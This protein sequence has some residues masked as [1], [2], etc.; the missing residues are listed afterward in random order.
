MRVHVV[1]GQDWPAGVHSPV[2]VIPGFSC[3][4]PGFGEIVPGG[5]DVLEKYQQEPG[6]SKQEN[7]L[8]GPEKC[9]PYSIQNFQLTGSWCPALRNAAKIRRERL[10]QPFAF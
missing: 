4:R 7:P 5:E 6:C 3:K 8:Q 9:F 2:R 10:A 1:V